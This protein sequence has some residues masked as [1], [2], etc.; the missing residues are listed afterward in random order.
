MMNT[1]GDPFCP[2]C[3]EALAKAVFETCGAPWDEAA[4]DKAHPLRLWR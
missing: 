4:Y 1:L 2:V 3:C